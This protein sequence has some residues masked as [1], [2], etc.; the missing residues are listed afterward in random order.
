VF[1]SLA[2]VASGQIAGISPAP[3]EKEAAAIAAALEAFR[4]SF[5]VPSADGGPQMSPWLQ[6]ALLD[7]VNHAPRPTAPWGS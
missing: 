6:A 1:D 3:D 4:R 7:G 5:A 2:R